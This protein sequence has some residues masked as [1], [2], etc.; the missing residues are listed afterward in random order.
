MHRV[1]N[2]ALPNRLRELRLAH[3]LKLHEVSAIVGRGESVVWR[4]ERG[5][6]AVPDDAKLALAAH[7]DVSVDY[8]MGWDRAP[9]PEAAA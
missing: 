9:Q 2:T 7:Y 5:L 4:Y 8:L 6:T 3:D 1:Q